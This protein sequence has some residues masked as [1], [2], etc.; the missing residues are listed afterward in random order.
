MDS[1]LQVMYA[2]SLAATQFITT[3]A[4]VR[5]QQKA[6]SDMNEKQIEQLLSQDTQLCSRPIGFHQSQTS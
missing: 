2:G 3:F 6:V 4:Q 5:A 1:L